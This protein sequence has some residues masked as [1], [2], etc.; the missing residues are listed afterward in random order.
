[1]P[2]PLSP[3]AGTTII[4]AITITATPRSEFKTGVA[5]NKAAKRKGFV[6]F[7]T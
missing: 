1:V 2:V 6:A 7:S 5:Q 3:Q 4:I